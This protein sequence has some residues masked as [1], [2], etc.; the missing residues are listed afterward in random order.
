M[1]QPSAAG[2]QGIENGRAKRK[3]QKKR[4]RAEKVERVKYYFF[5][6]ERQKNIF[7]IFGNSVKIRRKSN[8]FI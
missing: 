1:S 4:R 5:A 2:R 6:S 8:F 3:N 7:R